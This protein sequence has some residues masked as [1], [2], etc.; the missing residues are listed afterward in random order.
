MTQ[1][2]LVA[3]W[4]IQQVK[5]NLMIPLQLFLLLRSKKNLD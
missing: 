3:A 5:K 4:A 1:R 2:I